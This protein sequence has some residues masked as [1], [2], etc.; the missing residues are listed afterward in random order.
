M[1]RFTALMA[2]TFAIYL[3]EKVRQK[4]LIQRN[5]TAR[6]ENN[7]RSY[8]TEFFDARVSQLPAQYMDPQNLI[9]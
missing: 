5:V 1:K 6:S 4:T 3:L 7:D 8:S 9:W 2:C